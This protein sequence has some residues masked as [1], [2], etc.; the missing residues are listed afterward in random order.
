MKTL[1]V[2]SH[3]HWDREWYLT[4]QQ[5]RL[6]LLHLVDNLLDLLEEDKNFKYFML[7]GQTIVLDDY[8]LMRPEQESVLREHIRKGRILI[9]PWHI[10]PDMFLVGPEAHIRN[11]LQGDRTAKRFG[12]KMMVGYMPDSFGHIGQ[13]PQ[14]L[15]GFG[16]DNACLWRGLD[17][18]PAE[19]WWASPDGSRVLMA[20]LRNSYANGAG[21]P[22]SE[23]EKFTEDIVMISEDLVEHSAADD[24]LI[25]LGNDHMEPPVNTSTAIVYA[26]RHL[27]DT[28]VIHSTLPNYLKAIQAVVKNADLP[29]MEGE[30]RSSKRVHLLPGVLSTRMWIKQR[31]HAS[32]VLLEKWAEPFSTFA[33]KISNNNS[34]SLA[35]SSIVRHTAPILRQAWRL[36]MENHPHDS[37][38]GC[39]IDQVHE[40]MRPRFDQVDQIGEE[41][42]GQS[43]ER[44][45]GLID[46]EAGQDVVGAVIVFN[47]SS[48]PRTDHVMVEMVLPQEVT[49]FD[50]LDETGQV[51]P[52]GTLGLGSQELINMSFDRHGF[53]EAFGMVHE[54][55][56]AGMGLQGFQIER[57]G[58]SVELDVIMSQAEPNLTAWNTGMA[59]MG[60]LLDDKSITTFNVRA[61]SVET[62][63]ALFTAHAV[64]GLGY[65]TYF[66]RAR[67]GQRRPPT[68]LSPLARAFM[69]LAGR[70][71]QTSLGKRLVERFSTEPECRPPYRI[72]NEFFSVEPLPD[73]TLSVLDKG[74]GQTYRGLNRFM[75]GGDC[76][77]EYNYSPPPSDTQPVGRLIKVC[78]RQGLA[79]QTLELTLEMRV[80]LSL[81]EDRKARSRESETVQI[82]S[83]VSL[84]PGVPRIDIHTRVDN[85]AKDH[86]L[87]VH[88]PAPFGVESADYDGHFEVNRRPLGVPDYDE[89]WREEPRPEVPQRAFVDIS[90]GAQS[91][92]ITNRGQPEVEVLKTGTG[93]EI[94]LTL[95]RS[96]GWLS[97]DDFS[98]RQGHAGPFMA[99]PGAQMFGTWDFDYSIIPHSGNWEKAFTQ[100]YGFETPLRAL[101]TSVHPGVL[102]A[103]S[104][105]LLVE[106][107][108][109]VV[110]AV[111]ETEDGRGWLV[112]GYNITGDN[113]QVTVKPWKRFKKAER[114]NL[115]EEK[116]AVIKTTSDGSVTFPAR[117]HEIVTVVF[118]E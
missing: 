62:T 26:D 33:E 84:Y 14:I 80:P 54:G 115:G 96:V 74:S 102:P 98:T 43:L 27:K 81:T 101:G 113:I 105:L 91:L 65:R 47:P 67:D 7:D 35:N 90:G 50:L 52:H 71:T 112:R 39:S 55:R 4:F 15:R 29:T 103:S 73:G 24:Y 48:F 6:K 23:P 44:L 32:E 28:K 61:R 69:P 87:R 2:I 97:R 31:N 75:D 12:P 68:R 49:G 83:N 1:H 78:M 13:M 17:D 30:L 36:L 76:G 108:S 111:K 5:F 60:P 109:F 116:L 63:R 106:P 107:Q 18:Q 37:I 88:F 100:A 79:R 41:I 53:L 117:R 77:D 10:L 57:N 42:T 72:E 82:V 45:A 34:Q 64:P 8:L 19:F 70:L 66:L 3:T 85:R 20:Y 25:M 16:M 114:A 86:R 22:A 59:Q 118:D 58:E 38:C 93:S 51:I 95:L 92:M 99:T 104:S 110:S 94:A 89:S 11:L 40:E 46:T 56:I 9:G 21:L